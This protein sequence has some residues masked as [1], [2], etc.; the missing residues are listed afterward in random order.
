MGGGG[1]KPAGE[2]T[3]LFGKGDEDHELGIFFV[4]KGIVSAVKRSLV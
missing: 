4:Q 2:Y 1:T 3:F